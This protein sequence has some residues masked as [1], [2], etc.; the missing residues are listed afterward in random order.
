MKMFRVFTVTMLALGLMC[1]GALAA[2]KV[3]LSLFAGGMAQ[4]TSAGQI[5]KYMGE[6]IPEYS[7][8][9]LE[10]NTFY[11]GQLGDPTSMVQGLQQGTVDIGVAGDAYFSGLVPQIQVFELPFMFASYPEARAAV[12]GPVGQKIMDM[13]TKKGIKPLGFAEIGFRNLTNSVRPVKTPEDIKGVKIRTL[14]AP[15]QVKTWELIGALPTPIDVNELYAALQQG[16]VNA[17]ENP[18]GVVTTQKF[19]EVQKYMSMTGHV[20]TPAFLSMSMRTWKKLDA[21]QQAAVMRAAKEGIELGR[22]HLDDVEKAAI[23]Q[24]Q[25]AG[26]VIE[27]N[28][29]REK[30]KELSKSAYSFYTDKYGDELIKEIQA[31]K[32]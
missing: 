23:K 2:E 19:Y 16:V 28:P 17:Q 29:E 31:G 4:Q 32:K 13:F 15:V 18:L 8:G 26:M 1:S 7:E 5:I 12:D 22:K 10:T 20:Y 11:E 24:C 9:T 14:P 30:F 21:K 25:D 3:K 6:K 27:F